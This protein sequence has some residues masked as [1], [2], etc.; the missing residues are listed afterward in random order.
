MITGVFED[1]P[2]I[3]ILFTVEL[4]DVRVDVSL[5]QPDVE[6]LA[7]DEAVHVVSVHDEA[8]VRP[9]ELLEHAAK[10]LQCSRHDAGTSR[11][12]GKF[13]SSSV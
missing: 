2:K 6:R 9:A 4:D 5:L 13:P 10:H 11:V 3:R 7:Q 8:D 12:H 1:G